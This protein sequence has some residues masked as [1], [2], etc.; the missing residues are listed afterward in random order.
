[1]YPKDKLTLGTDRD[2]IDT[3]I[4]GKRGES[5]E[6]RELPLGLGD[7]GG[8]FEVPPPPEAGP[9][10]EMFGSSAYGADNMESSQTGGMSQ[11]GDQM[12]ITDVTEGTAMEGESRGNQT[13]VITKRTAAMHEFI[14]KRLTT[15]KEEELKF[16]SILEGK[17]RKTVAIAFFELLGIKSKNCINLVQEKPYGEILV[18]ATEY[19]DKLKM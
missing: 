13:F 11:Y 10:V 7:W 8:D 5:S 2:K 1:M 14:K 19:F 3:S 16:G 12:D 6:E 4:E 15:T 9:E 17:K 18:S